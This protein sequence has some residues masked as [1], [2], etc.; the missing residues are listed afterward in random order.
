MLTGKWGL[1]LRQVVKLFL[2]HRGE[3]HSIA[4]AFRYDAMSRLTPLVGVEGNGMTL[5]V[6]TGEY[7]GRVIY[8]DKSFDLDFMDAAVELV[9]A[10]CGDQVTDRLLL[11]IGANIGTVSIAAMTRY[12]ASS[13]VAIEPEAQ[14][15]ALLRANLALNDLLDRVTIYPVA[16]SD[17]GGQGRLGLSDTN[18][19]DHRV[20]SDPDRVGV[21]VELVPFASLPI[22][23]ADVGLVWMDVQGHEGHVFDGAEGRLDDVPIVTEFWWDVLTEV[24]GMAS[25]VAALKRRPAVVDIRAAMASGKPVRVGPDGIDALVD[26]LRHRVTDLLLLPSSAA[27]CLGSVTTPAYGQPM[28]TSEQLPGGPDETPAP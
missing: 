4:R 10:E 27:T 8:A 15:L 20:S 19:G 26:S 7:M 23:M 24:G 2:N 13:V 16:L 18:S 11:D 28:R 5:V 21:Q 3:R 12:G 14:N 6:R 22:N 9:M 17:H 1:Q 25:V